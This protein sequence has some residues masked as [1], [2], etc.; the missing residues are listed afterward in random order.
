MHLASLRI[1]D[2]RR[3]ERDSTID[4]GPKVVALIGPNESGK[5]S[6]LEALSRINQK[7]EWEKRDFPGRRP[8]EPHIT[9]LFVLDDSDRAALSH[10]PEA[11]AVQSYA[12]G[13]AGDGELWADVDP[14]P[15][16]SRRPRELIDGQLQRFAR[17]VKRRAQAESETDADGEADPLLD[18]VRDVRSSLQDERDTIP[19][20]QLQRLRELAD[21]IAALNI[22]KPKYVAALPERLRELADEHESPS[23]AQAARRILIDREPAFLLFAADDRQLRSTYPFDEHEHAPEPLADLLVL[24]GVTFDELRQAAQ[25]PDAPAWATLVKRANTRL[26]DLLTGYWKQSRVSIELQI[27]GNELHV[28]PFDLDSQEHSLVE[29][30]SDG[31]RSFLALLT[32]TAARSGSVKPVLLID[33]AERHLHYDAQSDL[34]A[35]FEQQ[36]LAAKIIYTTHSAACLPEDLGTGVRIV[37]PIE[38][39]RSV[40]KN[41]FWSESRGGFT[42][43]LLAMGAGAAAFSAVRRALLVEGPSDALLLPAL[44]RAAVGLGAGRSL[45]FQIAPGLAWGPQAHV[46]RLSVEASLAAYVVDADEAGEQIRADLLEAGVDQS[47]I[48]R[49]GRRRSGLTLEDLVERSTFATAFNYLLLHLRGSDERITAAEL[50]N[51]GRMRRL[52]EWCAEHSIEPLPKPA[53]AQEI[54]RRTQVA[55]SADSGA[56]RLAGD[57]E[58]LVEADRRDMLRRVFHGVTQVLDIPSGHR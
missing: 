26:A 1:G 30:R 13:K 41:A 25:E 49:L 44:F 14:T 16:R 19:A 43:L 2:F 47:L 37:A 6:L 52:D 32:F 7:G 55:A 17:S 10:I 29:D 51:A 9:A 12:T 56:L 8:A 57:R 58:A 54:L 48:F 38:G 33:E 40:L 53:L 39:D 4:V 35:M 20:E 45:G 36:D 5:T 27:A 34:V 15:L 50:P 46:G 3:F 22:E 21:E 31:F 23:P 42:P 24:A 18:A 28:Y 11:G